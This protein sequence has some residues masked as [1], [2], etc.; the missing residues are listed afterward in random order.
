MFVCKSGVLY[1]GSSV[2]PDV[3]KLPLKL[4]VDPFISVTFP[5]FRP[6]KKAV[7]SL[8]SVFSA[9][10]LKMPRFRIVLF[11]DDW[12]PANYTELNLERK[13]MFVKEEEAVIWRG[14]FCL[15]V[16]K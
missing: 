10:Y 1:T 7:V 6:F 4:T 16:A 14:D 2:W 3:P 12:A 5:S 8:P 13:L 9:F 11:K 15:Y